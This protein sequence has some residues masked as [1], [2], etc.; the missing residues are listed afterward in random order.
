MFEIRAENSNCQANHS[1][2]FFPPERYVF[3]EIEIQLREVQENKILQKSYIYNCWFINI[4]LYIHF[5]CSFLLNTII[6]TYLSGRLLA[7]DCWCKCGQLFLN[8]K[9]LFEA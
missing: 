7:S 8:L 5:K 9:K 1:L 2:D 3:N 4:I 6:L